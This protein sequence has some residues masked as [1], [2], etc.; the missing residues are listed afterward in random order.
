MTDASPFVA[1]QGDIAH[2]ALGTAILLIAATAL[3][4]IGLPLDLG[5]PVG[6]IELV[7]AAWILRRWRAQI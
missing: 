1:Q 4:G 2:W 6:A 5:F 7:A 3:F